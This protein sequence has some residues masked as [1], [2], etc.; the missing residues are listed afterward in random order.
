MNLDHG[1]ELV[2]LRYKLY[3]AIL[4]VSGE[5]K[6]GG[7]E[8]GTVA[9]D[10]IMRWILNDVGVNGVTVRLCVREGSITFYVSQLIT[11]SEEIHDNK[12]TIAATDGLSTP[13]STI[14]TQS[15]RTPGTVDRK[16]RQQAPSS[17]LYL[18]IEGR[19]TMNT[20][21]LQSGAGNV[22]FGKYIANTIFT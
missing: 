11:P 16:R 3:N 22:T 15:Y 19:D 6:M 1:K 5:T 8:N 7:E 20:F 4:I 14:F 17:T 21:V 12:S 10:E 2:G 18:S 9:R 13:C